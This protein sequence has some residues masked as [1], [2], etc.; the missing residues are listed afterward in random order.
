MSVTI[1]RRE[2]GSLAANCYVVRCD[3]TGR[4]V[5]IDPGGDADVIL[6]TVAALEA[7]VDYIIDTHCHPDHIAANCA[8]REGLGKVQPEAPTLLCHPTE[9]PFIERPPMQWLLLNMRPD[10]CSVDA[11]VEDGAELTFGEQTLRVM[12][13]PGHSPGSI[14]LIVGEAFFTGD[15]LF[16]GGVGR[17]DFPGGSHDQLMTSLRRMVDELPGETVVYP[18]HGPSTTID[19][20]ARTNPWL[21]DDE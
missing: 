21:V 20:E 11:T 19:R 1:R 9:R 17:T 10:P 13:T 8:V 7:V 6:E 3:A 4:A 16:A 14:S 18:G 2:V 5:V 12:H 15:T